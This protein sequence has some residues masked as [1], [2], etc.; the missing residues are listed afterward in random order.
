M[1]W[2]FT[3]K[4]Q[5]KVRL[6]KYICNFCFHLQNCLQYSCLLVLYNWLSKVILTYYFKQNNSQA[7]KTT[8]IAV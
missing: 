2:I 1:V 6:K 3:I 7:I 8:Q 5:M 4:D